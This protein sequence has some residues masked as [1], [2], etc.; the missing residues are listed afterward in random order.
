MHHAAGLRSALIDANQSDRVD[1]LFNNVGTIGLCEDNL[2]IKERA[3]I[4]FA[5]KLTVTPEEMSREDVEELRR[6]TNL[7][8]RT[9]HDVVNLVAY[10]AFA[11]RLVAGLGV[12]VGG[13]EGEPGQ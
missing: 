4:G 7:D 9:I 2:T 1:L 10:Y 6:L 12:R 5:R 3:I 8:D 13:R 11:N